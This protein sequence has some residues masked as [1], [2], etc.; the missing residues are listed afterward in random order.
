M[1]PLEKRMKEQN[2]IL[3]KY[4]DKLKKYLNKNEMAQLLTY[5]DQEVPSGEEKVNAFYSKIF[6]TL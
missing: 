3:F 2:T 1:N 4:R 6:I 5:N